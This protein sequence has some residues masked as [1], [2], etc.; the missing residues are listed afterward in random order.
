MR[1]PGD[2]LA[3]LSIKELA[4]LCQVSEKTARRWKAGTICPPASARMLIEGDLGALDSAW[5]GWVLR[6]GKLWSPD[7]VEAAPGDIMALPFMRLQIQTYQLEFRQL[8]MSWY[9][10][11]PLPETWADI[12]SDVAAVLKVKNI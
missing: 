10:D 9:E 6:R 1:E 5:S 4:A 8:K 12:V 11:Q 3:W 2:G 7:G